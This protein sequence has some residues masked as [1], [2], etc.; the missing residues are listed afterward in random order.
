MVV[1]VRGLMIIITVTHLRTV[2]SSVPRHVPHDLREIPRVLDDVHVAK[3]LEVGEIR[4]DLLD[5]QN[6]SMKVEKE[7]KKGHGA[8][9]ERGDENVVRIQVCDDLE[10]TT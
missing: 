5:L 3:H 1:S 7:T 10:S 8:N 9:L 6:E 2:S 4:C